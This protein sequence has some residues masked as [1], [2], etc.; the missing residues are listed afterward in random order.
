MMGDASGA[1]DAMSSHLE[2]DGTRLGDLAA[3]LSESNTHRLQSTIQVSAS[4]DTP[5]F[6]TDR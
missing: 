3:L 4:K 6:A 1:S 2:L 5:S